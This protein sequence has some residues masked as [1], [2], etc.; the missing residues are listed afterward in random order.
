M[1]LGGE[2][3]KELRKGTSSRDLDAEKTLGGGAAFDGEV[4]REVVSKE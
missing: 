1:E 3:G 4:G 2:L